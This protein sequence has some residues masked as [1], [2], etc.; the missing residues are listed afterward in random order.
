MRVAIIDQTPTAERDSHVTNGEAV[1]AVPATFSELVERNSRFA[2]RVAFV[3]L[4][5]AEDAEDV[6]QEMF[7][8]LFRTGSWKTIHDEHSFLAKATWR[9]AIERLPR[10]AAVAVELDLAAL[11]PDPE[12]AVVHSNW[13]GVIHQLMAGLPED[14]R[15][16]LALSALEELNSREIAQIMGIPEGTVRHRISRARELLKQKLSAMGV[17]RHAV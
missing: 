2:F 3:V 7:L 15:R 17:R 11:G 5:N 10:R 9:M 12:A 6:V 4:R 1:I 13:T 16:P 8:K 14:L